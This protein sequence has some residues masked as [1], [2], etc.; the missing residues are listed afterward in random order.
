MSKFGK[1]LLG[2]TLLVPVFLIASCGDTVITYDMSGVTFN[3][4]SFTYDGNPH[5][6]A[7]SGT[8]PN[9][10]NVTYDGNGKV[11]AGTYK[12]TANFTGDETTKY[13][14]IDSL[15][16]NMTIAQASIPGISL[17]GK[18]FTYDGKPHSLEIGGSLPKGVS[19]TY[20]ENAKIDAGEYTITASFT[21]ATGNY[22]KLPDL[23]AKMTISKADFDMSAVSFADKTFVYDGTEKTLEITGTLPDGVSVSYKNNKLTNVGEVTSTA[24][25]SHSNKNYNAIPDK[26]AKLEITQS[27]I[28][29]IAFE[30]IEVTYDGQPH[31][32]A[33]TGT[34][35]AGVNVKYTNNNQT[36]AGEYTVT[37]SFTDT[38][39]NYTKLPD[40]TAKIVISKADF[41]MS[42]VAFADKTFVYD[43]TEK[44][45]EITGTLPA[46][47][48]VS[49]KNN[50]LTNVGEVTATA[51]FSHSNKNYNAIPDKTAELIIAQSDIKGISFESVQVTYDGQMHS[52]AITGTLPEGVEV[53]YTNNNK[54]DAGEYEVTAHFVAQSGSNYK[55]PD[56]MKAT[57]TINKATYDMSGVSFENTSFVYSGAENKVEITGTLPTG[58]SVKYTSNTLTNV[59]S[60][61]ATAAFT[62]DSNNYNAIPSLSAVL[63]VTKKDLTTI[64]TMG[65]TG[66]FTY[67][68]TT[69]TL[70]PTNVPEGVTFEALTSYE[71]INA[72]TYTTTYTLTDTTGNYIVKSSITGKITISAATLNGVAFNNDTV[73]YDG[74]QHS[75]YVTFANGQPASVNVNYTNN[76][77]TNAGTYTVTAHFSDSLG[78]YVVPADKTATL[79]ISKATPDMSGITFE[80]VETTYT[81]S[82]IT[83]AIKGDLPDGVTVKSYEN[84][85]E[86]NIGTYT[87]VVYFNVDSNHNAVSS[88]TATLKIN[89]KV[90]NMTGVTFDDQTDT[91]LYNT[92][93]GMTVSGTIPEGI[94]AVTIIDNKGNTKETNAGTYAFTATF[95]AKDN[96]VFSDGSSTLVLN[97]NLI[98][99][100]QTVEITFND[101][102]AI[103]D[104]SSHSLELETKLPNGVSVSYSGSA[105]SQTAVGTYKT[106]ATFTVNDNYNAISDVTITW[107]IS[108]KTIDMSGVTF[109]DVVYTYSDEG[110]AYAP[111]LN[112][113]ANLPAGIASY[114]IVDGN[115]KN[116][117]TNAGT[118]TF[119][120]TFTADS[121]HKFSNGTITLTLNAQ[122]TI[123]K[124]AVSLNGITF[125]PLTVTYDGTTHAPVTGGTFANGVSV[126]TILDGYGHANEANAG[127][128]T[129]TATFVV[130][131]NHTFNGGANTLTADL[132]INKAEVDLA[133][134]VTFS[135]KTV[136]YDG[137]A[138]GL[139]DSNLT[140]LPTGVSLVSMLDSNNKSTEINAGTYTFT[141]TFAVDDNHSFKNGQN[142]LTADLVI[143]KA[144]IDLAAGVT[145]SGKT[146]TYDGTAYGLTDSNLTALPTGVSLVSIS[147]AGNNTTEIKAG[148]YTFTATF[149]VDDNH[150]FKN[151]QNTLTADLVINK[152][153][154]DMSGIGFSGTTLPYDQTSH[155]IV[156]TG[157]LPSTISK[158]TYYCYVGNSEPTAFDDT[159][160]LLDQ[161]KG[162]GVY[163][164]VARFTLVDGENYNVVE[165]MHAD[166]TITAH[167]LAATVISWNGSTLSWSEVSCGYY[168]DVYVNDVLKVTRQAGGT[169]SYTFAPGVSETGWSIYIIVRPNDGDVANNYLTDSPKSNIIYKLITVTDLE[170]SNGIL[171]WTA[172]T[173][174]ES[175]LV[176]Y[177]VVADGSIHTITV[178]TNFCDT[179]SFQAGALKDIKV[180]AV[181][182]GTQD[183]SLTTTP[184][185]GSI[186]G[187]FST[188]ITAE[189]LDYSGLNLTVN[190]SHILAWTAVPNASGYAVSING[191]E[192]TFSSTTTSYNPSEF[193]S[194]LTGAKAGD[195]IVKIRV[196][197]DSAAYLNSDYSS[198]I[199]CKIL[200]QTGSI[201]ASDNIVSWD[202]NPEAAGYLVHY[203][204]NGG[205]IHEIDV[206]NSGTF[207]LADESFAPGKYS[208]SSSSYAAGSN[209][210]IS[211]GYPY[212]IVNK[213]SKVSDLDFASGIHFTWTAVTNASSYKVVVTGTSY[214]KTYT[215][216]TTNSF[217]MMDQV[218]GVVT[219]SVTAIGDGV[220]YF[221]SNAV[222]IN[223]NKLTIPEISY[224]G[225]GK[226]TWVDTGVSGTS[227]T[228][229]SSDGTISDTVSVNTWTIPTGVAGQFGPLFIIASASGYVSSYSYLSLDGITNTLEKDTPY[230]VDDGVG[231]H[232]SGLTSTY[233]IFVIKGQSTIYSSNGFASLSSL[234]AGTY[235]VMVIR[236]TVQGSYVIFT[237]GDY[238]SFDKLASVAGS[239]IVIDSEGN[240]TWTPVTGAAGYFVY[241]HVGGET[242]KCYVSENVGKLDMK[243]AGYVIPEYG[244]TTIEIQAID[245]SA[246]GKINASLSTASATLTLLMTPVVTIVDDGNGGSYS[247]AQVTG[248]VSY[249]YIQ[250][251]NQSASS[252]HVIT[253]STVTTISLYGVVGQNQVYIRAI[254]DSTHL[255][256]PYCSMITTTKIEAVA[257]IHLDA[258]GDIAF[259]LPS[260]A[261]TG[262]NYLI[263]IG[264]VDYTFTAS[265]CRLPS[266]SATGST[267]LAIRANASGYIASDPVT[268][269]LTLLKK[270]V[271]ASTTVDSTGVISW[272]NDDNSSVT[273]YLVKIVTGT[274]VEV[275][276][277]SV[278]KN[279]TYTIDSAILAGWTSGSTHTISITA[280]GSID[281]ATSVSDITVTY[282]V[283]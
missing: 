69:H 8:L 76:G 80:N 110:T 51:S 176:S 241:I 16:A 189:K 175:Y 14:P 199:T 178:T 105:L 248:A 162:V 119:T 141:A 46:G 74:N 156:I 203:M 244:A 20:K 49:Y 229:S 30:G 40:M 200:A 190:S 277:V 196:L 186:S 131:D 208:I 68:G 5:S 232:T 111:S 17:V 19:V 172:V 116:S 140:A 260:N 164:I 70:A 275:D 104:G 25:F 27:E 224:S 127:T 209:S 216:I 126:Y 173:N 256:S 268:K 47:V 86:T 99:N 230:V 6:I 240:L 147:D 272:T 214:S 250:I 247:W 79:T 144:E 84:A 9:G 254:G 282:T 182:Q 192:K 43:G 204:F 221:D 202:I 75:I 226:L 152:A 249:T 53:Q 266:I 148:T 191:T 274:T 97:A 155:T 125:D 281:N 255:S 197:G 102:S 198:E 270:S 89:P 161:A 82:S 181:G 273:S 237:V 242:Y 32:L 252:T 88:M 95:S 236:V 153:T 129:F 211:A 215:G 1:V 228:V 179:V 253:D 58:V 128:Y 263:R 71:F 91:Y 135:G 149:A 93:Y 165:D 18:T 171:T 151:G 234:A 231:A 62:G 44:S 227:Y 269:T 210:L 29:G 267:S 150:S 174:A 262:C 239:S 67:D 258:N 3:D 100:K 154:I 194:A 206:G 22:T 15:T 121:N 103:Y 59:G 23:T 238:A 168:Y 39:G 2:M 280:V 41:D 139:T 55:M 98:I 115:G 52:L 212:I 120:V 163:H 54:T 180:M 184:A 137:T 138:Y 279:M 96:Y 66:T 207:S 7:I 81:G 259:D 101:P 124:K 195:N 83:I 108:Q 26:T 142:T 169:M 146:V 64:I 265:P 61:T 13:T 145:F 35:P 114:T 278:G 136:T 37:A 34:L 187:N 188:T 219:I 78:N 157:T 65:G 246:N 60:V 134:S 166:I 36:D 264:G 205:T 112:D 56:D 106:T 31:S 72:G 243:D 94:N 107:T 57:L 118:Y 24:S 48:S 10:V 42:G 85:T 87:A 222:S 170:I 223:V 143:E 4:S 113:A 92:T 220:N 235:E 12:V 160:L 117:E 45:L 123:N 122:L 225:D 159:Y 130:D 33:I 21:D 28:K 167:A 73:T 133:A 251:D 271:L 245:G 158:V 109:N 261:P 218:S 183:S 50:K 213:L 11:N 193:G 177:T 185:M 233:Y 77:Q 38:T 217:D 63:T 201:V 90:I 257:N 283:S 132:I 276:Q